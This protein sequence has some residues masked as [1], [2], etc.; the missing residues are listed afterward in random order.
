MEAI[1]DEEDNPTA[2]AEMMNELR[3]KQPGLFRAVMSEA[4]STHEADGFNAGTAWKRARHRV[5]SLFTIEV[6]GVRAPNKKAYG[7]IVIFVVAAVSLAAIS[8]MQAE[9]T[10][11]RANRGRG[12]QF[13]IG[14][15]PTKTPGSTSDSR[16]L[17]AGAEGVDPLKGD[18]EGGTRVVPDEL[19]ASEEVMPPPPV[20]SV[21][22]PIPV[23]APTNE[24]P[25]L[26]EP[27]SEPA[28][29][30]GQGNYYG[31][32]GAAGQEVR[33]R[34]VLYEADGDSAGSGRIDGGGQGQGMMI[35]EAPNEHL[36]M[37]EA[38]N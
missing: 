19:D 33:P 14:E 2:W 35:F 10:T 24:P 18:G 3:A 28:F 22:K 26:V 6:E 4:H 34:G 11:Q 15:T 20:P 23:E 5:K 13:D 9:P 30:A 7:L 1:P 17:G 29:L 16:T 21:N 38:P 27:S 37:W 25:P 31:A 12:V 8:F 36:G 32:P